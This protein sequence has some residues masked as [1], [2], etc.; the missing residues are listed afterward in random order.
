MGVSLNKLRVHE[1]YQKALRLPNIALII[2]N[3]V[4]RHHYPNTALSWVEL[5]KQ[6]ASKRNV[7][8]S[9]T[10]AQQLSLTEIADILRLADETKL[11]LANDIIEALGPVNLEPLAIS[12]FAH[13]NRIPILTTNY[14]LQLSNASS[15]EPF[16]RRK[17]AIQ[18]PSSS[19]PT[20]WNSY[21]GEKSLEPF[22]RNIPG[23][24][25]LHGSIDVRKSLRI[26]SAQYAR[27]FTKAFKLIHELGLYAGNSC[28]IQSC[29][30]CNECDWGGKSTWLDIFFHK[31][32]LIVGF[33]F[34][35][36]ETLLRSLLIERAKY[37]KKRYGSMELVPKSYFV[38]SKKAGLDEGQRFFFE[39][40][41]FE[42]ITFNKQ[43]EAFEAKHFQAETKD[44][45]K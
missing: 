31:R 27:A 25:H 32:L 17:V 6:L 15:T 9:N 2:G 19:I 40:L 34:D 24:W 28:G 30:G 38:T 1:S 8:I 41:G 3:G 43:G 36:S 11:N 35:K 16:I 44:N 45:P 4:N 26:T 7:K 10:V 5:V 20:G 29:Q 42:L 22:A 21:L 12:Y 18:T 23:L 39:N 33:S 13:K 14:D 37:L